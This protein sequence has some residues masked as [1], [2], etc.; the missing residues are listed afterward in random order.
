MSQQCSIHGYDSL[1][2]PDCRRDEKNRVSRGIK[3]GSLVFGVFKWTG[4]NRYP[5]ENAI[6][7]YKRRSDA[8]RYAEANELVVRT[9]AVRNK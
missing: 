6:K 8:D 5:I 4:E 1:G 2:C 7:T 9:V 3:D